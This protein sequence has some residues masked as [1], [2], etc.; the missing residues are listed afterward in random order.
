MDRGQAEKDEADAETVYHA[1]FFP[2]AHATGT[3]FVDVRDR[4]YAHA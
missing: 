3:V 4:Y 2:H 1:V